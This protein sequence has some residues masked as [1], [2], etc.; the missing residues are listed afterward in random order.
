M[1]QRKK[2]TVLGFFIFGVLALLVAIG[3]VKHRHYQLNQRIYVMYF[4]GSLKGIHVGTP[5]THRGIKIGE[6]T[7]IEIQV[8]PS[9]AMI[10]IPIYIQF[11]E[12]SP[13]NPKRARVETLIKK[14]IR[15]QL[16]SYSLIPDVH[17]IEINFFPNTK[18]HFVKDG[19][20]FPEIPTIPSS[21][22]VEEFSKT[23][24]TLRKT[25]KDIDKLITSPQ[26]KQSIKSLNNT[27]YNS[28]NLIKTIDNSANPVIVNLNDTLLNLSKSA[29]S[30]NSLT[31]YLSQHPE[32]LISG[33]HRD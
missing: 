1:Q 8:N 4:K 33:K 18:A 7:K 25:V 17:S 19:S 12:Y 20:G 15:A 26:I 21:D 27:L 14:G 9:T 29:Y 23:L 3:V 24:R 32:S 11:L 22:S 10:Q 16:Q 13:N 5:V 28:N 2:A 6:V 30:I 31:D